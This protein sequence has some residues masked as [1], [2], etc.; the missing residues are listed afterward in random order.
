MATRQAC[1]CD[2]K[3]GSKASLRARNVPSIPHRGEPRQRIATID[4]VVHP[5]PVE[6]RNHSFLPFYYF[7]HYLDARGI[8]WC[9]RFVIRVLAFLDAAHV[10]LAFIYVMWKRFFHCHHHCH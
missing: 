10:R 6:E 1:G 9:A 7:R 3:S 8:Q 2:R 4:A 5:K